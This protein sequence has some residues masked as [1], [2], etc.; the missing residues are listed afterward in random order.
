MIM[1]ER[2]Y[3]SSVNFIYKCYAVT[4]ISLTLLVIAFSPTNIVLLIN[5]FHTPSLDF[6]FA[7]ITHFGNGIVLTPL[8]LTLLFR[9]IYMALSL[10]TPDVFMPLRKEVSYE[11]HGSHL[12]TL[13]I[14]LLDLLIRT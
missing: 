4:L 6:F 14:L 7:S 1:M 2:R 13:P 10:V 3:D 12:F 8:I 9:R 5:G 11:D